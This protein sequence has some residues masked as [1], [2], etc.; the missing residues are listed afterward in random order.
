[1][2]GAGGEGQGEGNG[3]REQE[4]DHWQRQKVPDNF[5]EKKKFLCHPKCLFREA[6]TTSG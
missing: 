5:F 4:E 3:E 1:M 2:V 6:C